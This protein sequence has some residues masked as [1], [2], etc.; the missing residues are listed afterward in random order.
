MDY[1]TTSVHLDGHAIHA[2]VYPGDGP[3]I[4]L[5]HGFPDNLHLYDRVIPYLAPRSII[6]FD[7][8]GWGASDKPEDYDYTAENQALELAAVMDQLVLEPAVL[9]AHD[10]SG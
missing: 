3:V 9:V 7:F 8:L 10:A 4:V 1:E 5:M 6:T 2:R